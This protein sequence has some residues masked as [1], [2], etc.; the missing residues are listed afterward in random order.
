MDG[1]LPDLISLIP[2]GQPKA[3]IRYCIGNLHLSVA[4]MDAVLYDAQRL[5]AALK[6][7]LAGGVLST[8]PEPVDH[9]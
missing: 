3:V 9:L 8:E 2:E 4:E 7:L 5:S 6:L 1:K